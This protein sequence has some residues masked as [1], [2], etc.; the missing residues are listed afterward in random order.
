M[1][2]PA[3]K[4]ARA[5]SAMKGTSVGKATPKAK[6]KPKPATDRMA[7]IMK[8]QQDKTESEPEGTVTLKRPAGITAFHVQ[9]TTAIYNCR[10]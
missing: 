4:T 8:W 6:G 5:K 2:K 10:Q 1:V 7:N 3:T 9:F